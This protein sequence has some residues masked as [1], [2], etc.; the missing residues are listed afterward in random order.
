L[1]GVGAFIG[2]IG[3]AAMSR[4]GPQKLI[5]KVLPFVTAAFLILTGYTNTFM[6]AGLCL[7]ATGL[8]FVAFTNTAN[9]IM[10]LNAGNEYRGRVMSVFSLVFNG[11]TPIGNLYAGFITDRF[12]P[13]IGFA[14]CGALTILLIGVLY[15]HKAMR[16][17]NKL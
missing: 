6:M 7:A 5:I 1:M 17:R 9:S 8:F 13:R 2:A 14:A 4:M 10:Q 3:M 16:K 11:S 15:I 12:G